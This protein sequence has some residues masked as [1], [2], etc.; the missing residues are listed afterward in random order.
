MHGEINGREGLFLAVSVYANLSWGQLSISGDQSCSS[1]PG[2]GEATF[3]KGNFRAWFQAD[4]RGRQRTLP[5]S[6]NSVAF[7]S[8]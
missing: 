2:V 1:F 7:S 4:K 3:T 5:V 8:K 6:V